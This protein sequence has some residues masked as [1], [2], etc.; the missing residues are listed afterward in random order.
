VVFPVSY[1]IGDVLTEV[2]GFKAARRVIWIGFFCNL[3]AALAIQ[4][5]I[6]LPPA[7]FW[8]DQQA[9]ETILGFSWR[10]LVAS[11]CAFLVGEFTN[12][13]IMAKMK[14]ATQGRW[15]WSRTIS[16]TLVAEALDST[17]FVTIAFAGVTG[18]PL[19]NSISTNWALKS[20]YEIIATPIT[21]LVV[22][23][24]KRTEGVD[25]YDRDTRFV[26]I[27]L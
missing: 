12:S 8:Q 20:A 22:G 23:Y 9:Y 19:F 11:F 3:L 15:L 2:W 5:A 16:S 1:I 7:G 4:A 17:V 27:E 18:V 14:V 25:V 10:L 24:L 6:H 13:V 21:Y 26:P